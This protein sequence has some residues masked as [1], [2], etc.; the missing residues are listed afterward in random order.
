MFSEEDDAGLLLKTLIE[1]ASKWRL[2]GVGFGIKS[3]KL[4][5]L[6]DKNRGDPKKC[7]LDV[8]TNWLNR[9]YNTS[10]F[11]EPSWRQVVDV[12][13]SPAAGDNVVLA[14]SVAKAHPSMYSS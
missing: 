7:F 5:E 9:N 12:I 4:D 11:G 14:T 10:K 13:A 1:V 2:I 8:L 6:E 3:G